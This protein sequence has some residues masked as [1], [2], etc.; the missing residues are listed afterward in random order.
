MTTL[1]S[2]AMPRALRRERAER[3]GARPR[4]WRHWG[5]LGVGSALGLSLLGVAAIG[6][7]RP[8]LAA[9]QLVYL[10]VGLLGAGI[11]AAQPVRRLERLAWP[12]FVLTVVLMVFLLLPLVPE[13]IVRPRNGARRW[14]NVGVTY[15]QPSELAKMAYILAMAAWLQ[16]GVP[17]RRA[18]GL[19]ATLAVTAVPVVLIM[20]QPDLDSALLF[21]PTLL[22]MLLAAG[23]R[24]RHVVGAVVVALALAPACYP[25]LM[26]H[27]R[28]RVDA[29][30][31]QFVGDTRLD[32]S[33]GFQSRRAM[34]L[35]GAGGVTGAGALAAPLVRYNRLPEEHNDMIFVVIV[36]RWGLVGGVAACVLGLLYGV[37]CL[38]VA[39]RCGQAF[40]RLV[41]VGIG[42][43][44]FA[45][46]GVN[47]GMSL[48][49]L[50][51]SGM[52]LPFVSHGGSSLVS[53]WLMT[54]ALL[55]VAF[56]QPRGFDR[57]ALGTS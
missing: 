28:A 24:A 42:A 2:N 22:A 55:C 29:L 57:E 25:F 39:L 50:P 21:L 37:S 56:H 10:G 7:T 34:T 51:V 43:M 27:Q 16:A 5:W 32:N 11:V 40:G 8:D 54:G 31:S 41:A 38:L 12:L 20:R 52:T 36:C 9:G 44:V 35:A 26:P 13:S 18:R 30:L 15:L 33:T 6:T 53:L 23:A 14:I 19:L 45:Q 48:G 49:I 4:V 3:V 1:I 46:L 17:I 47:A